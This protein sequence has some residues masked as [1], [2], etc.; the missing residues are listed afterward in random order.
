MTPVVG[1]T[2]PNGDQI[3]TIS[4]FVLDNNFKKTDSYN[5]FQ[6]KRGAYLSARMCFNN[7]SDKVANTAACD[8]TLTNGTTYD[9]SKYSLSPGDLNQDGIVNAS[10]FSMVKYS[11]NPSAQSE[12]GQ[13]TDLNYDGI[14]NSFDIAYL[15]Q[16]LLQTS[17]ETIIDPTTITPT[18]TILPTPTLTNVAR[19]FTAQ[20]YKTMKYWLYTPKGYNQALKW[21]LI[22]WL[23]GAGE[24]GTNINL[25]VKN[26]AFPGLIKNG[27]DYNAII[28]TPQ[29]KGGS[30]AKYNGKSYL[31]FIKD[32]LIPYLMANYNID[33]DRISVVGHSMGANNTAEIGYLY[34]NYFSCLVPV[35]LCNYNNSWINNL[36]KENIKV[37]YGTNDSGCAG[38]SKNFVKAINNAGG[39]ATV[40]V[41]PQG[42][43]VITNQVFID[44]KAVEWMI[45]QTLGQPTVD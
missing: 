28:I 21:P 3:Y 8:L 20:E 2:N 43:H 37:F 42:G 6:I 17:D 45:K 29:Y 35:S 9:F 7:Q 19:S 10:D 33:T 31:P 11:I 13:E 36:K 26:S 41:I 18:P 16:S 40:I 34:P 14:T 5:Y 1:E 22:I 23:H 44:H 30:N 15:K 39:S 25:L 4:N 12:C 32:E 38:D 24:V 27:A